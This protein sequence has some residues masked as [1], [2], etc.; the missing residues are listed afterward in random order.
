MDPYFEALKGYGVVVIMAYLLMREIGPWVRDR[1]WPSYVEERKR[2]ADAESLERE[3][4]KRL[5]ERQVA[6]IES[7][8]DV[9]KE[10]QLA[11][12]RADERMLQLLGGFSVHDQETR[13]AIQ[14]MRDR[15]T[16]RRRAAKTP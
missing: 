1:L 4:L 16:P 15:T 13:Q 8:A 3:R 10:L 14:D 9:I 11:Q 12:V 6:A 7:M 5:E 2:K